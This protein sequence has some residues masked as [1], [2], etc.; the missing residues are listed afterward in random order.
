MAKKKKQRIIQKKFPI[1]KITLIFF[2]VFLIFAY[3]YQNK[4]WEKNRIKSYWLSSSEYEP[5]YSRKNTEQSLNGRKVSV[6]GLVELLKPIEEK[7]N[8]EIVLVL[9]TKENRDQK[10]FEEMEIPVKV[11]KNQATIKLTLPAKYSELQNVKKV[12]IIL[13]KAEEELD[14]KYVNMKSRN[15]EFITKEQFNKIQY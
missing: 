10:E 2:A 11:I 14:V 1:A 3:M 7:A 8:A 12:M 6:S 4:P 13:Y 9:Y 15:K 5:A